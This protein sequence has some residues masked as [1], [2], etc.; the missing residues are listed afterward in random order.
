MANPK[1][2]RA[3]AMLRILVVIA[4]LHPACASAQQRVNNQGD[5]RSTRM[6]IL[7]IDQQRAMMQAQQHARQAEPA[8]PEAPSDEP[9][10]SIAIS[11][12]MLTLTS[13]SGP[14]A[15]ELTSQLHDK[16]NNMPAILGTRDD[17]QKLIGRLNVAGM[18][19]KSR[20]VRLLTV[21]GHPANSQS[22][23]D[24][25]RIVATNVSDQ[26]QM[27]S[28][29]YQSV[30]TIVRATPRIDTDGAIQVSLVYNSSDIT[31]SDDVAISRPVEGKEMMA[32]VTTKHQI[33]TIVRVK[34][35]TAALVWSNVTDDLSRK[36]ASE[37]QMIILAAAV[38][39]QT[40]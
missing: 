14:E 27:N 32:D 19:R 37:I 9:K 15:D 35:G 30:G 5:E 40:E 6:P 4:T 20:E 17:V 36:A 10:Q 21:N 28:I 18:L 29:Q 33:E 7:T 34:N 24:E 22:G 16:A 39:P 1:K 31:K 38:D 11:V 12:W 2:K 23:A 25:P 13:P 3:D 8:P 26:G